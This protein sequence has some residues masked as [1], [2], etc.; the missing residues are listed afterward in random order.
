MFDLGHHWRRWH[1][2][3]RVLIGAAAL[4]LGF[5][6]WQIA[7][8][9]E[10]TTGLINNVFRTLQLLTFQFPHEIDLAKNWQL[11]VARFLLPA[12]ALF[13]T[14]RLIIGSIRSPARLAM[15]GLRRGHVVVVPGPGGTGKALLHQLRVRGLRAV[16]V[17]GESSPEE[18]ARLEAGD[19]A[20]L[21]ADP[22]LT[23]TWEQVRA[24]N[25]AMVFI[26]RDSDV[27]NLNIVVA[28]ADALR[29][30]P[31]GVRPNLVTAITN[32]ALAAQVDVALDKA[33]R[34][35]GL[36]YR[37]L[38]VP[39]EAARM[40]FLDPPLPNRKPDRALASHILLVGLGPG[41]R[42][43]LRHAA[44]LGQDARETGPR[45]T[46]VASQTDL[47]AETLLRDTP[48]P[49]FIAEVHLL[50]CAWESGLPRPEALKEVLAGLPPPT[51]A[52]VC[53]PDDAAVIVGLA[54]AGHA[55][56]KHWPACQVAVHQAEEDRFLSLLAQERT[57]EGHDRLRPF[58]GI[59]PDGTLTRLLSERHDR[60]PRA[61]HEH[62]LETL[63]RQGE[64]AGGTPEPWDAL[65]E[66]MR[67]ANRAAADHLT[68]KLAA[69]GCRA[70]AGTGA[71]DFTA[72]EIETLARIE[73]RRWCAERVLRGW[74]HGPRDNA[75]R[76]HPD[77]VPF[78]ELNDI[79]QD[80]DRDA[81]RALPEVLALAGD[82]IERAG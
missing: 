51:L 27:E 49:A 28:V 53:L 47:D 25:A 39:D 63:R 76:L 54:L 67:H 38:S 59:L 44:M 16:A 12:V 9:P 23:E 70:V 79:A 66:N 3:L 29:D 18:I 41:A 24:D 1:G 30:E 5:W 31:P 34:G 60:L 74:R 14:Y 10:G 77:L 57:G 43:V 22:R 11:N 52:C 72:V 42:A 20:V 81:V 82:R 68:V 26:A 48:L 61:V 6:G 73:H 32:D 80:K 62:Y 78:D 15:L 7:P 17:V 2:L 75:A 55:A 69:I 71:F 64:A 65:P 19:I 37:R 40:L 13:E 35:S 46:V 58:G 56:A 21:A 8:H 33:A 36:R 4:I 45:I 50:P